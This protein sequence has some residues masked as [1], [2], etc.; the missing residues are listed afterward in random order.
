MMILNLAGVQIKVLCVISW[1]IQI[2]SGDKGF[3]GTA[4]KYLAD[5]KS[6]A[7]SCFKA[8]DTFLLKRTPE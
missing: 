5:P 2:C 1:K 4:E 7:C 3:P 6:G 8:G